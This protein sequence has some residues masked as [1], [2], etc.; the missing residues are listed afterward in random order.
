MGMVKRDVKRKG[1]RKI[2]IGKKNCGTTVSR[3]NCGT[4]SPATS[5]P[6]LQLSPNA[7]KF[8]ATSTSR[9]VQR[10]ATP[11][12]RCLRPAVLLSSAEESQR[13]RAKS[14]AAKFE[15][16]KAGTAHFGCSEVEMSNRWPNA[17]SAGAAVEA[18]SI[19]T[20]R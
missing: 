3:T 5:G 2:Q 18:P 9:G 4:P 1:T 17:M 13:D 14:V 7:M 15:M 8:A 11:R 6:S 16:A 10:G 19:P 12:R 20:E